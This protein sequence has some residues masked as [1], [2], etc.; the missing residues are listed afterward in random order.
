M[1]S[2]GLPDLKQQ[3]EGV[4]QDAALDQVATSTQKTID[5][6]ATQASETFSGLGEKSG[7]LK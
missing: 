5:K 1:A 2:K 4:A 6:T 3:V 7:L